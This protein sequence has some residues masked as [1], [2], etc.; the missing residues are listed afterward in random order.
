MGIFTCINSFETIWKLP[1]RCD[2]LQR[3]GIWWLA[4][5]FMAE[6]FK[7]LICSRIRVFHSSMSNGSPWHAKPHVINHANCLSWAKG[8]QRKTA[9][10]FSIKLLGP[11]CHAS[12]LGGYAPERRVQSVPGGVELFGLRSNCGSRIIV[13]VKFERS[14]LWES[15]FPF[16]AIAIKERTFK[17]SVQQ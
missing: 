13:P 3:N 14:S 4:D 7:H 5:S 2:M 17:R 10:I 9:N 6:S 12:W 16:L 11:L 1:D 8:S 15:S